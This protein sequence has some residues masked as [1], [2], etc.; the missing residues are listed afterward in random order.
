MCSAICRFKSAWFCYFLLR[1]FRLAHQFAGA[2]NPHKYC[3][4]NY[5]GTRNRIYDGG[6][7]DAHHCSER[8]ARWQ[9]ACHEAGE[10]EGKSFIVME[11]LEGQTLR[12]RLAQGAVP[13]KQTMQ[14]A[15]EIA[16]ALAE[17]HE[18]GIIHRDLKPANIMLLRT[19]YAKVMD[20]GLAKQVSSLPQLGSRR[21][22]L[23]P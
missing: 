4:L 6:I 17:A 9:E 19:G 7:S 8:I 12:D 23:R 21:R 10:A 16:E 14:W 5:P 13:L 18:K 3:G 2:R 11:Y 1:R 22:R 15:L 20:F